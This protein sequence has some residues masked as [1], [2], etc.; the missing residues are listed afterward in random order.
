MSLLWLEQ[1]PLHVERAAALRHIVLRILQQPLQR[2]RDDT[3]RTE[4]RCC[5]ARNLHLRHVTVELRFL[6][7]RRQEPQFGTMQHLH[8]AVMRVPLHT[9]ACTWNL[10]KN[11]AVRVK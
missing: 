2:K 1:Q 5:T 11:S 4:L 6:P 10:R 8:V 9:L 3:A 7:R